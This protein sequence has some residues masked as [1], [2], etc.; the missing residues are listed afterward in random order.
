MWFFHILNVQVTNDKKKIKTLPAEPSELLLLS[1]G[2]DSALRVCER[3]PADP[4]PEASLESLLFPV[5]DATIP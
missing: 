4:A 5:S 3:D 2:I 1:E